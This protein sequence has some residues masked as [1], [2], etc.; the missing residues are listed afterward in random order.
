MSW[1]IQG[2]RDLTLENEVVTL[3]RLRLD[4]KEGYARIAYD[5]EIWTYFVSTITN[6]ESLNAFIE[7]AIHDALAGTRM[8]FSIIDKKTG[9]IAG[10]TAYGNLAPR[11]RRLEIGWS[12]LGRE[13][14]GTEVNRATKGLLLEYAFTALG[15]ERVEFKTD[16]LNVRARR[17]LESI[18][19]KEEGTLRSFNYMPSG[20]RRDAVYYS[21]LK[22]E[23]PNVRAERFSR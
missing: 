21:I 1:D 16:V 22:S 15:C 10:S 7:Q 12:W 9:R 13:F 14:R 17:G 20:R 5:P 2:L 23:W 6:E 3:R 18:G 8:V 11:E 19:A 4:D